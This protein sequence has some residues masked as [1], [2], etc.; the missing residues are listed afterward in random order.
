MLKRRV[1]S[2]MVICSAL[3]LVW[4]CGGSGGPG[5]PDDDD[6]DDQPGERIYVDVSNAGV[7]DGTF[8]HPYNTI[9]EGVGAAD[10]GDT[11]IVAAGNYAGGSDIDVPV[12]ITIL[13]AGAQQ[14]IVDTWFVVSAPQ[15]TAEV[16]FKRL[17]FEGAT[18]EGNRDESRRGPAEPLGL[19]VEFA[20]IHIDSCDAG[21]VG[22]GY[23]PDHCYT[24]E[25]SLIDSVNFNHGF[26]DH[27]T[28]T[29]RDCLIAGS[30]QCIHGGG[31]ITT[32]IDG[33]T[34]GGS[35]D[36]GSGAGHT[37]TISN[38]T[39]H[40]IRDR[41]GACFTTISGN[42]LPTGNIVDKSGGWGLESQFID[43][44]VIQ[45]GVM[46]IESGTATCRYNIVHAPADTFA[47]EMNCGAPSIL[48]GNTVTLPPAGEPTGEPHEWRNVGIVATCGEGVI[49]DNTVTGGSI[50][51]WEV[52][53]VTELSGNV[54]SGS[55]Y[56]IVAAL[57][58]DKTVSGNTVTGCVSDGIRFL[59]EGLSYDYGPFQNNTVTDNGGA[60]IRLFREIDLGGGAQGSTGGNVIMGNG[61][62]D[63]YVEVPADSAAV[64]FA[65]GNT[66]DHG[67][68]AE[69]D[70]EDVYDAN[71]DPS[72]ADVDLS[73]RSD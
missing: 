25:N 70:A 22:I 27:G 15:D 57:G 13:G 17:A 64:I 23:P 37:F 7:E 16:V 26:S 29:V 28:H 38:N 51:I 67:S 40:G 61:D 34:I 58:M 1:F 8:E 46:K 11:V 6:D 72:L 41:S 30:V 14:T 60:G 68:E 69:V 55:H 71:D 2:A 44:N 62:Y 56:G 42:T 33:C 36:L 5:G 3:V 9:D 31:S 10:R 54:V 52:S 59:A 24:V 4:G 66:W 49:Q 65:R 18:F 47:I 35:I 48:I 21:A 50:G 39:V 32:L 73:H 45:N 53:G 12:A 63:L 19:R 43:S 20:P